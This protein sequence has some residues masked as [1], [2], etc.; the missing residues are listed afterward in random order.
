MDILNEGIY[1]RS[2]K[3][4]EWEGHLGKEAKNVWL[5]GLDEDTVN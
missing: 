4:E 5:A 1:I 2:S 3:K